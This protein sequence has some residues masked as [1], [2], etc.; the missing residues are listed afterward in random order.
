MMKIFQIILILMITCHASFCQTT[1]YYHAGGVAING[2]DAVSYF[3]DSA[4]IKGSKIFTYTWNNVEWRFSNQ[5]N[6]EAFKSNPERYAPQFGGFCAYGVADDHK[7]PTQPNAFTIYEGKYL[8]YNTKVMD[9]WRKDMNG[10]IQKA[11]E[12]WIDLKDEK[13]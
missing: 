1:T 8:N 3:L 10:Y 12:N 5:R 4:A 7:A 9:L 2:F 11:E 13:Y 6:L